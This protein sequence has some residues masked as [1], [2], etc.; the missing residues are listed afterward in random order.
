MTRSA[1]CKPHDNVTSNSS[2][3][4]CKRI[5]NSFH[6]IN[7]S[8]HPEPDTIQEVTDHIINKAEVNPDPCGRHEE[9]FPTP[10][11]P[12][13]RRTFIHYFAP[14]F[15]TD[16][17]R[18]C[19]GGEI[20]AIHAVTPRQKLRGKW[21]RL[22]PSATEEC[23]HFGQT[24]SVVTTQP[25]RSRDS[26]SQSANHFSAAGFDGQPVNTRLSEATTTIIRS[27]LG[28]SRLQ[29]SWQRSTHRISG[30]TLL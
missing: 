21:Q 24:I 6:C 2:R 25:H 3:I 5:S 23:H 22:P 17:Y 18:A 1:T 30:P 10:R 8:R 20:F 29:E 16:M 7:A 4:H 28:S 19:G 14:S 27:S 9:H 12:P 15:C 26:A 11:A 13:I